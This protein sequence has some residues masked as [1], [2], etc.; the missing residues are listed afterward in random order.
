MRDLAALTEIESG[1]LMYS[2][3]DDR[4][5]RFSDIWAFNMSTVSCQLTLDNLQAAAVGGSFTLDPRSLLDHLR[6][7]ILWFH[8]K[9]ECYCSEGTASLTSLVS[10]SLLCIRLIF[11]W[12]LL[13]ATTV[14]PW[15]LLSTIQQLRLVQVHLLATEQCVLSISLSCGI[16]IWVIFFYWIAPVDHH[17]I[18]QGWKYWIRI[19]SGSPTPSISFLPDGSYFAVNSIGFYMIYRNSF[20]FYNLSYGALGLIY[21]WEL[22]YAVLV[23]DAILNPSQ[24]PSLTTGTTGTT[25]T[26]SIRVNLTTTY[27]VYS[28]GTTAA[29]S[30]TGDSCCFVLLSWTNCILGN[31]EPISS[32][33]E[34]T[35][36][37]SSL[38]LVIGIVM[39]S[40][41]AVLICAAIA[42]FMFVFGRYRNM[43]A[44][45]P[46]AA[47]SLSDY[48]PIHVWS[49][50][51]TLG[52]HWHFLFDRWIWKVLQRQQRTW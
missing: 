47:L 42:A 5:Q 30:A 44:N 23:D 37:N 20:W 16:W 49:H 3:L 2:G 11:L 14:G 17:F 27:F 10:V 31:S 13:Q 18:I 43:K 24:A 46:T 32:V 9:M 19:D 38:V 26:T 39:L 45:Q 22:N 52:N 41:G 12:L 28:T 51:K 4:N 33:N 36:N 25:G 34:S 29:E 48:L 35:A 6:G 7:W 21:V 8:T 1:F 40:V 50:W 15:C